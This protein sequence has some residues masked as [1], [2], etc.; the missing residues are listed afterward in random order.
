VLL[1]AFTT[2]VPA[3]SIGALLVGGTFTVITMAG[4]QEARAIR[5][6]HARRLIAA[7]VTAFGVGQVVGSIGVTDIIPS[8]HGFS[9]ALVTAGLVLAASAVMLTLRP[10]HAPEAPRPQPASHPEAS[11]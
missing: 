10:R 1:P 6:E 2:G 3:L 11:S 8:A 7:M 9:G 5:G 4:F